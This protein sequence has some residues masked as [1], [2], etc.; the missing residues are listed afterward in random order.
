V[1]KR[2]TVENGREKERKEKTAPQPEKGKKGKKWAVL[3]RTPTQKVDQTSFRSQEKQREKKVADQ[4]E[5]GKKGHRGNRTFLRG[6]KGE[7][8]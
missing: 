5:G 4:K 3:R 8:G 1:A 7:K 6:R 2:S